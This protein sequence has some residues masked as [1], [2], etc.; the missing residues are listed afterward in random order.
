MMCY[1]IIA[2][3]LIT[4]QLIYKGNRLILTSNSYQIYVLFYCSTTNDELFSYIKY[5]FKL[6]S[7][8]K[9]VHSLINRW[10]YS[11]NHESYDTKYIIQTLQ[12]WKS[13]LN[14]IFVFMLIACFILWFLPLPDFY[15]FD[16]EHQSFG[17]YIYATK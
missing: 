6:L 2:C 8:I 11:L 9:V 7:I 16:V 17:L 4:A 15:P 5:A 12:T 1:R 10:L 3:A 14:G 13:Y